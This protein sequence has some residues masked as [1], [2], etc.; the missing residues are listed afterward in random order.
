M[1]NRGPLLSTAGL[2]AMPSFLLAL[3]LC[4]SASG[5][6]S[7]GERV[8]VV[9]AAMAEGNTASCRQDWASK[10]TCFE[11]SFQTKPAEKAIAALLDAPA[12]I[13]TIRIPTDITPPMASESVIMCAHRRQEKLKD[14][15]VSN[16][17]YIVRFS[18]GPTPHRS[19][20]HSRAMA[21]LQRE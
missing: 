18:R 21:I 11:L 20:Q 5:E 17:V 7:L 10:F 4:F 15:Q 2:L 16:K 1:P 12:R 14:T 9:H 19:G 6:T 8:V 13:S 3:L